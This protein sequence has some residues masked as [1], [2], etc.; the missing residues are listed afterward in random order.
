VN[1]HI[2]K[3]RWLQVDWVGYTCHC[4]KVSW[5]CFVWCVSSL[6]V[7][8]FPMFM[9]NFTYTL[10]LLWLT[11]IFSLIFLFMQFC[12]IV[13]STYLK[14]WFSC[15]IPKFFLGLKKNAAK[16]LIMQ[17]K[18]VKKK[19]QS[20]LG[21]FSQ[22]WAPLRPI[23]WDNPIWGLG[24]RS[25]PLKLCSQG[26]LDS[27]NKEPTPSLYTILLGCTNSGSGHSF[28]FGQKIVERQN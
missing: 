18:I 5:S 6:S 3:R 25:S 12:P 27:L 17:W 21:T 26:S 19:W 14:K 22:I 28:S 11:C 10:L 1:H 13:H 24:L 20:S 23:L 8:P 9:Q 7:Q 15:S 16:V 4:V 2:G